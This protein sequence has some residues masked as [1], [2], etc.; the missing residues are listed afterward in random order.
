MSKYEYENCKYRDLCKSRPHS[1][2]FIESDE[3]EDEGDE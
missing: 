1:P 3:M 2:C